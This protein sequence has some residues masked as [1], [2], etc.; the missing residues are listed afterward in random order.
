MKFFKSTGTFGGLAV[1]RTAQKKD[2]RADEKSSVRPSNLHEK[3]LYI[4]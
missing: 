3:I 2:G 4:F 1:L